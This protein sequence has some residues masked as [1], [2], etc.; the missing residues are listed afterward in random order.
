M[1]LF[2]CI[3]P[4]VLVSAQPV[5][6]QLRAQQVDRHWRFGPEAGITGGGTWMEGRS[7]PTVTSG[8]APFI[9]FGASR[10]VV[11]YVTAGVVVRYHSMKLSLAEND[12]KWSGGSVN[13]GMFLGALAYDRMR[14]G[15]TRIAFD[16][17]AGVSARSGGGRIVPF[18]ES[19]N[20]ATMEAGISAHKPVAGSTDH[21][22]LFV[23][24]RYSLTR[25][26]ASTPDT[27]AVDGTVKRVVAGVG[28]T[29]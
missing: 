1:R 23:F 11:Q 12:D 4:L 29:L 13:E 7:A 16:V 27:E 20:T 25:A 26:G 22:I 2:P 9:G 10:R 17:L 6:T 21:R 8:S 5:A 14:A 28:F 15:S 24:A 3:L 19:S 18:F